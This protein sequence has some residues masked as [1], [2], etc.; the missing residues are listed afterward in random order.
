M[1]ASAQD[2]FYVV[3]DELATKVQH[4]QGRLQNFRRLLASTNTATDTEFKECRK[5]LGRELKSAEKQLRDL[6]LTVELV[7]RDRQQFAHIDDYELEKRSS[8]VA[9]TRRTLSDVRAFYSGDEVKQKMLADERKEIEKR[10]A[11]NLGAMSSDDMENT[12]FIHDQQAQQR[13][14]MN[15]QD[16]DLE[17][18]GFAVDRVQDMAV[19]INSELKTQNRMLND[20]DQDLDEATEKMNFVMGKLAKLLKTKDTCQIWTILALTLILIILIFLLIY[21]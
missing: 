9:E 14:I 10:P 1:A 16:E 15:Q 19:G 3:K 7:Q 13:M 17:E 6:N 12:H 5:T 4:I 18:L 11:S 20:L 21:T 2:P 8:Y